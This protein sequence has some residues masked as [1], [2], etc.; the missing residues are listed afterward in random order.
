VW[1]RGPV[2]PVGIG[3]RRPAAQLE[4]MGEKRGSVT[5]RRKRVLIAAEQR[6]DALELEQQRPLT[7]W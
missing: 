2:A 4:Q 6:R 7:L 5:R 1:R 3:R